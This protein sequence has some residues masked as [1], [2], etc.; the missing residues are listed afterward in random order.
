MKTPSFLKI[1][2]KFKSFYVIAGGLF[3]LWILVFDTNDLLSQAKLS[4]K[5]KELEGTKAFYQEKIE[6]VKKDRAGLLEDNSL[7][8]KVA[9]ER[10]FMRKEG[11]EVFIVVE[12]E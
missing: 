2:S 4:L 12:E 3:L 10:Y 7:L 6:E 1:P 8:E 9:R 11:E 5:Q